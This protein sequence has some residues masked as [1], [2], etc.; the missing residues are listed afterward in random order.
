[1]HNGDP[2]GKPDGGANAT[3]SPAVSVPSKDSAGSNPPFDADATLV[4]FSFSRLN[5]AAANSP[6][7]DATMVDAHPSPS[8]GSPPP[9]RPQPTTG[10]CP[11]RP[12]P[13]SSTLN[14]DNVPGRRYEILQ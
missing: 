1:M 7:P 5:A 11:M 6:D 13:P 14:P 12:Q 3:N 4:D 2:R 9:M 8:P 10:A